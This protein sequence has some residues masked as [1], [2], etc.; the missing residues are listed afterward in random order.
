MN[1]NEN[2][3]HPQ[4]ALGVMQTDIRNCLLPTW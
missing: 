1:K 2:F 3:C 4:N